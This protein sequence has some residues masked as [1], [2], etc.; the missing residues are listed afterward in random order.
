MRLSE[1]FFH[2]LVFSGHQVVALFETRPAN[3]S[4]ALLDPIVL[5]TQIL[6]CANTRQRV[7]LI[8]AKLNAAL[9]AFK[10]VSVEKYASEPQGKAFQ[11]LSCLSQR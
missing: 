1:A 8:I 7:H 2:V 5:L 4:H 10:T 6:H 11:A 3:V 9:S